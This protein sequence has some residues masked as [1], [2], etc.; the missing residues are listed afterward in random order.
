MSLTADAPAIAADRS[1]ATAMARS[2]LSKPVQLALDD[3][4]LAPGRA[5]FDYGCGRGGDINR[6]RMAGFDAGG[7]DPVH[8]SH[9]PI[10][11]ADVVNLGYVIN[12]IERPT[13]RVDAIREAW[14]LAVTG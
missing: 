13:E 12:V 10:Y 2:A 11:D 14:A 9:Q 3:G 8:A 7:W 6:L 5:V 1:G 4:V